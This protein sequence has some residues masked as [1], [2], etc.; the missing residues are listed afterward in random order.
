MTA[1]VAI[2]AAALAVSLST[3]LATRW[4]NRRDLLLRIHEHL[5]TADQQRGRRLIYEKVARGIRPEALDEG[6]RTSINN[7]LVSLDAMGI[8][9]R[10]RYFRRKDLLELWA[11]TVVRLVRAAEPFMTYSDALV[12]A[13]SLPAL[14]AFAVDAEQYLADRGMS[15]KPIDCRPADSA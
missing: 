7:A 13:D 12:G 6:E 15:I 3:I 10:R 4:R 11:L 14:R 2:S 1:S 9:H 5:I 8:Y